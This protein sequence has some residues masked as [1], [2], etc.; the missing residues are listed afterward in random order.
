MTIRPSTRPRIAL[1]TVSRLA[2]LRVHVRQEQEIA[3]LGRQ[4]VHPAHDLGEE[5]AVKIGQDHADRPG[6]GEAEAARAGVRHISE[7]VD[8]GDDPLARRLADVVDPIEDARHRC[9]R[10]LGAARNVAD[11]RFCHVLPS[12][13][14]IIKATIS[15]RLQMVRGSSM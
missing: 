9:H 4:P 15:D 12:P 8:R 3:A 1:S 7:L 6:P 13:P 2:A 14:A 11:S 5:L 10:N